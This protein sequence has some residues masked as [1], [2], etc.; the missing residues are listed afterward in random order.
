MARQNGIGRSPR[1]L[2]VAGAAIAALLAFTA[3]PAVLLLV[4]GNPLAGGLGHAWRPVPR[5]LLCLLVLAAWV[6]WA[7]CC[8]QLVRAVT[9]HV[10]SGE[11]GVLRGAPVL[12]RV[13]ARIAFGVLTLTSIGAPLSLAASAVADPPSGNT[14]HSAITS[15]LTV[16]EP[17]APAESSTATHVVRPGDTLWQIAQR[18]PGRRCGLDESRRAQS[19]P[20]HGRWHTLR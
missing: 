10:R 7:A 15:A 19:R 9:A 3:V 8:T 4:V 20:R 17:K 1:L 12:D 16:S 5:D 13:A 18:S 14:P 6:A 2:D 11:V